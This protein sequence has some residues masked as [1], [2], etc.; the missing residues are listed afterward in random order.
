MLC[1]FRI[2]ASRIA[3][4]VIVALFAAGVAVVS[5]HVDDCHDATC[6]AMAVAHDAAAHRFA[7][8]AT[9][10]DAHPL[11]CPVCHL[12]RAFRPQAETRIVS[13][14]AADAITALH[15]ELFTAGASAPAARPPLRAPPTSPFA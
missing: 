5:P 4:T 10:R 13:A 11:H 3:L 8:P 9:G 1:C 2:H 7:A 14:P 6:G 15:I 12:V